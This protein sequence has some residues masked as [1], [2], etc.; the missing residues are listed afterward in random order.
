MDNNYAINELHC[1]YLITGKNNDEFTLLNEETIKK[2]HHAFEPLCK[3]VDA[4]KSRISAGQK[5]VGIKG[6]LKIGRLKWSLSDLEK[7]C[8]TYMSYPDHEFLFTNMG[9]EF[10]SVVSAYKQGT[11]TQIKLL[12]ENDGYRG[13]KNGSREC[14][15][16]LSVRHDVFDRIGEATVRA[17]LHQISAM[18]EDSTTIF[19]KRVFFAD[20]GIESMMDAAPYRF[21]DKLTHEYYKDW[22]TIVP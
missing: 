12:I 2:I 14:G 15:I 13:R 11:T 9:A 19:S 1:N 18:I 17:F 7:L 10:P 21:W 4:K 22:E 3:H 8:T 6:H 5:A 20:C 16:V